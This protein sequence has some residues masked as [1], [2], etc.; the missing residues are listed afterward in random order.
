MP[1]GVL[2]VSTIPY[3]DV[4]GHQIEKISDHYV[5]Y[6]PTTHYIRIVDDHADFIGI[7]VFV[8]LD[9]VASNYVTIDEQNH[10]FMVLLVA[11]F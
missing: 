9:E 1:F 7:I 11:T 3:S 10:T 5:F 4:F 6:D 8:G 2:V